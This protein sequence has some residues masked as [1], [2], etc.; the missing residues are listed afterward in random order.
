MVVA[1][2]LIVGSF[3]ERDG[4]VT[5]EIKIL[6]L[7]ARVSEVK[8]SLQLCDGNETL[9]QLRMVIGFS[10]GTLGCGLLDQSIHLV[11]MLREGVRNLR[12]FGAGEVQLVLHPIVGLLAGV[13]G[14]EGG[15]GLH[16]FAELIH[17]LVKTVASHG[18]GIACEGREDLRDGRLPIHCWVR[19]EGGGKLLA[20]TAD[21]EKVP[22]VR[23]R[24]GALLL[25][26][27]SHLKVFQEARHSF[28]GA[29]TW[30]GNHPFHREVLA[31]N[32]NLLR[33][34][35]APVSARPFGER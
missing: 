22:H 33:G 16:P 14:A 6:H 15:R 24:E 32:N 19:L 10:R 31:P 25:M 11:L 29:V 3:A 26:V 12:D 17:E 20:V 28:R 1:I 30:H 27:D 21:G 13:V 34:R 35:G 5:I 9:R 8:V 2:D 23:R 7:V 4:E 18:E